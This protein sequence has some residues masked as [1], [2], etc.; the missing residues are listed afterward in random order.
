MALEGDFFNAV[1]NYEKAARLHLTGKYPNPYRVRE[2]WFKA[3]LCGLATGDLVT[4]QRNVQTYRQGDPEF[5]RTRQC[6]LLLDLI[7]AI[8]AGDHE[9]FS[10]K[11]FEY[12]K[13]KKLGDWEAEILVKIKSQ[14]SE[15][16]NEFA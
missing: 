8:E 3:G 10:Q 12:D 1:A 11:L 13:V 7:E 4:A 15:A 6:Q 16:D 9:A 14:I 5:E 2:I